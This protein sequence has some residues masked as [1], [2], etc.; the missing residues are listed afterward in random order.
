MVG[1]V[2][3]T[4]ELRWSVQAGG[5]VDLIATSGALIVSSGDSVRAVEEITGEDRW[6]RDLGPGGGSILLGAEEV[7]ITLD[8]GGDLIGL[9]L[10]GGREVWRTPVERPRWWSVLHD[11]VGDTAVVASGSASP[12]VGGTREWLNG[13]DTGT[14]TVRWSR[15][16]SG[17]SDRAVVAGDLV[18]DDAGLHAVAREVRTGAVVW[19]FDTP[20]IR[21]VSPLTATTVLIATTSAVTVGGMTLHALD[22]GTGAVLWTSEVPG[23]DISDPV[24]IGDTF[25]VGTSGDLPPTAAGTNGSIT[26][27][28]LDDGSTLW[29]TE[30]RD[31]VAAR[32]VST[33]GR[34]VAL[35]ADDPLFCD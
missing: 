18:I 29:R 31:G 8:G 30:V 22:S 32:P 1:L 21:Q 4:G 27:G 12:P 16:M 10:A 13:I 17:S 34:I 3:A 23:V 11:V 24:V 7:V 25:V 9:A 20:G 2:P 14:G 26:A 33:D 28:R 15:P 6:Q 35:S 19:R 5:D